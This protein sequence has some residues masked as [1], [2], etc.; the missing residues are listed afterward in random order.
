MVRPAERIAGRL[1]ARGWVLSGAGAPLV[2]AALDWTE[3]RNDAYERWRAA[4]AEAAGTSPRRVLLTCVHPHDAP[5]ADL[6]AQR[7]LA[8]HGLP[9]FHVDPDFHEAAVLRVAAA[10]RA[11]ARVP[12]THVGAGR[13]R[14][15][16]VACNRRVEVGGRVRFNRYSSTA[17]PAVRDAP[18]G[19]IDPWLSIVSFWAG[20][21]LLA[22][23]SF[24]AVHPMSVYGKGE[25]SG[26]FPALARSRFSETRPD[27]FHVYA[28]GAAGD[29]TAARYNDGKEALAGRL[30]DAMRAAL[31]A[32]RREPL[33]RAEL[34][35]TEVRFEAAGEAD[36]KVLADPQA[37]RGKRLSHALGLSWKK[38]VAE[39]RPVDVASLDLGAARI[40]LLPAESFVSFQ[41]AAQA[42]LPDSL[43]AVAAYGECGPGY[44]P[45]ERA[46]REGFVEEHG[47]CWTAPGAEDRLLAAIRE[48]LR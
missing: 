38:R 47:Y 44:L 24:Y 21:G 42:L 6:E 28:S 40:L 5:Y 29:V 37:S 1:E 45:T 22:T 7:L 32:T 8:A 10:V 39:G 3:L 27:G 9:G 26:D 18:D 48:V 4:L 25:V 30:H 20:D 33:R 46:R 43:V 16:R 36:E 34:R 14:V 17:D 31:S 41:L 13:A 23:T 15:D 19:E 12:V 35:L 2:F 11:A